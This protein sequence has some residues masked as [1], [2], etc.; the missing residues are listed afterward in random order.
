MTT[1]LQCI[2]QA[3]L[4]SIQFLYK[5]CHLDNKA[6]LLKRAGFILILALLNGEY[7]L[8]GEQ[9]TKKRV[10]NLSWQLHAKEEKMHYDSVAC[11]ASSQDHFQTKVAFLS[12]KMKALSR[13]YTYTFNPQHTSSEILHYCTIPWTKVRK[14]RLPPSHSLSS[15]SCFI[16]HPSYLEPP[17]LFSHLKHIQLD[18]CIALGEKSICP[19]LNLLNLLLSEI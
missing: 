15:T 3:L 19:L 11:S 13:F 14:N 2:V 9:W 17:L 4:E 10:T 18:C 12:S 6:A 5:C 8:A 16:R 7:T 1:V